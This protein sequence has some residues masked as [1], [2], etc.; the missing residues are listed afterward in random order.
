MKLRLRRKLVQ[1]RHASFVRVRWAVVGGGSVVRWALRKN[2]W[3]GQLLSEGRT[4]AHNKLVEWTNL[5]WID[6]DVGQNAW[7][8]AFV[9]A[10]ISGTFQFR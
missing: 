7:R 3:H 5:Y 4:I 6:I 2:E 1:E 9:Y 8:F 10:G